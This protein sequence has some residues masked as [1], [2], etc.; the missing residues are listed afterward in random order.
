MTG[1]KIPLAI[2]VS[3]AI[4]L[5][6]CAGTPG[7]DPDQEPLSSVDDS[8]LHRM[9]V[10]LTLDAGEVDAGVPLN[11][12]LEA[13][14]GSPGVVLDA[15]NA[16]W[17]LELI[18]DVIAAGGQGG[19]GGAGGGG[20]GGQG[21]DENATVSVGGGCEDG[22]DGADGNSTAGADGNATSEEMAPALPVSLQN[23]TGLPYV[24]NLTFDSN[25]T[26]QI[27][28]TVSAA[29]FETATASQALTVL[30]KET[31]VDPCADFAGPQAAISESGMVLLPDDVGVHE[32]ELAACHT[33]IHAAL[34][35]IGGDIDLFL[36]D[37]AGT[38]VTSSENYSVEGVSSEEDLD[39]KDAAGFVSGT[40]K[41]E[42]LNYASLATDYTLDITFE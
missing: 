12:S 8:D 33:G 16:T 40:W 14:A 38:L 17:T 36:Y 34:T 22:D 23:G 1:S 20:A 19:Q 5:S 11:L 29:G 37:P 26:F 6:G 30:A 18:P 13:L 21:C 41:I 28:A 31:F 7:V 3:V 35:A 27:L 10:L 4:A 24:G 9:N 39:A 42:V 32:F 15:A 2:A 25:G